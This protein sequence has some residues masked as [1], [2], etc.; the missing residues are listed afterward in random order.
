VSWTVWAR[1][2]SLPKAGWV[3]GGNGL[4]LGAVMVVE[5]E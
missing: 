3:E 5:M 1:G 2:C 4:G